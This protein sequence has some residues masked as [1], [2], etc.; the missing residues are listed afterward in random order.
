MAIDVEA[1]YR[2]HG[3]MVLRRCRTLLRDEEDAVDAM[4]DTF[5]QLVR[6]QERLTDEGP[7]R[8]LYRMA[9]AYEHLNNSAQAK[10]L[11]AQVQTQFPNGPWAEHAAIKIR[12]MD[13]LEQITAWAH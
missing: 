12:H 11:Y 13:M 5:L 7:S 2:S 4:Q 9:R 3:P 6:H 8:L 10:A 1:S